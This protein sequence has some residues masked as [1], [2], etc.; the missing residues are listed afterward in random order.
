MRR[1]NRSG[2]HGVVFGSL[3]V[4]VGLVLLLDNMGIIHARDVW[5]YWPLAI[6][7]FGISR[8]LEG[9]APAALVWGG[10]LTLFGALIFLDTMNIIY[11]DFNLVWPLLI[12]GFG[13]AFLIRAVHGPRLAAGLPGVGDLDDDTVTDSSGKLYAIFGGGRRRIDSQQFQGLQIDAVF[14]GYRIDLRGAKLAGER[15]IIEVNAVFGGVEIFV[16]PDWRVNVQGNG[17]FGAFEDKTMPLPSAPDDKR[18]ELIV[19]GAAVFGGVTVR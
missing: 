16:P 17:V 6:V 10:I 19:T 2:L 14:G 1:G 9:H 3:I 13:V 12:I 11:F 7:A 5:R 8:M 18:P 15:A 4:A